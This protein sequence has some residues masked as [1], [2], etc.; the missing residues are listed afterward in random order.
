MRA[1]ALLQLLLSIVAPALS[2]QH[3]TEAVDAAKA[4][5]KPLLVYSRP[6]PCLPAAKT[7]PCNAFATMTRH[8]AMQRRLAAVVFLTTTSAEER[9]PWVTLYDPAGNALQRWAG[10][11]DPERF[12][13]ILTLVEAATP[14]LADAYRA[15]VAGQTMATN[16]AMAFAMLALGEAERGRALLQ[17]LQRAVSMEDRELATLWLEQLDVILEKRAPREELLAE[18]SRGGAT[19]R[20]RFEA[21]MAA[22]NHRTAAGR[23]EDAAVAYDEALQVASGA[24][25]KFARSALR[26]A[27]AGAASVLGLGARDA[28]VVGRRTLQPR[29]WEKKTAQIEYRLDGKLVAT[30]KKPPF[31][32]SA[33]FGPIPKRQVLQMTFRDG[34]GAALGHTAVVVNQRSDEFS[35]E[36]VDPATTQLSGAV[37]VVVDP[38]VPRER[39]LESVVIEWNGRA[40]ARLT[41]AP[42][43]T[44]MDIPPGERGILRAV[45]RL[46]DGSETED[47]V[48]ANAGAGVLES[49]VNLVEVPVYFER[50]GWNLEDLTIREAGTSRTV[51]RVIPAAEAPLRIALVLDASR[52]M[53]PHLL[54]VKEASLRFVETSLD[55]RDR[56]MVVAFSG[57]SRA[58]WPTSDRNR[59]ARAIL[60]IEAGGATS[61]HDAM[62]MAL[63]QIQAAG[64]RRA[65]VVFS[66]GMDSSSA[67][68]RS[69]VAEVARRSGVPVYLLLITPQVSEPPRFGRETV[70]TPTA[71]ELIRRTHGELENLAEATGGK[72][73]HL[74]SLAD[75]PSI[76]SQ[77]GEDLRKQSLVIYR[78]A[79]QGR[80]WRTLQ[81][82]LTRGG[83]LRAPSGVH[84]SAVEEQQEP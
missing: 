46:D 51:D 24:D 59:I 65:L 58:L 47:V 22:G 74:G 49:A 18:L 34:G 32:T 40:L 61:L 66:D 11:P 35:I 7:D 31:A 70:M 79:P 2:G 13:Q 15:T 25:V 44:R 72:S 76:W 41:S 56:V 4:E 38:R 81:I 3:W 53:G 54:D 84:V 23:Y 29:S 67:F 10:T 12:T 39:M 14:H 16:R 63:L 43:R 68:S 17:A 77:I 82:A 21:W 80:E 26:K 83:R 78:A 33:N 37:T 45:L 57:A 42:Y 27:E 5:G 52:S 64:S 9:A 19:P 69:D 60:S 75:L 20:V 50:A 6:E 71:H 1:I 28:I 36:I 73:F 48:L 30:A 55:E 8:P 62:I